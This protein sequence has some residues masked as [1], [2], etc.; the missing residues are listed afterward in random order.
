MTV[1]DAFSVGE[2]LAVGLLGEG[3][4]VL[5]LGVA[6][7]VEVGLAAAGVGV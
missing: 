4:T 7:G 6:L 2:A 3:V 1:G 5:I